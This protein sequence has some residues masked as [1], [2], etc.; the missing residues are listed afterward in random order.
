MGAAH[1]PMY[2]EGIMGLKAPISGTSRKTEPSMLYTISITSP[3][4]AEIAIDANAD[5]A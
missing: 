1:A 3:P 5:N 2:E 4:L